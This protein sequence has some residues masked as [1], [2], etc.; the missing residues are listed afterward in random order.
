MNVKME[1]ELLGAKIFLVAKDIAAECGWTEGVKPPCNE[2]LAEKMRAFAQLIVAS[3]ATQIVVNHCDK[4]I[5][6]NYDCAVVDYLGVCM[7]EH[8]MFKEGDNNEF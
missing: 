8:L 6:A 5:G 4:Y 3:G 2:E 1:V 7:L